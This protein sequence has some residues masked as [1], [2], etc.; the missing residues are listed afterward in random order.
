MIIQALYQRYQNQ[1]LDPD[2]GISPLYYS[3]SRISFELLIDRSGQLLDVVDIRDTNGRKLTAVRMIVPEQPARQSGV[4]PYFL[5]DKAEYLLAHYSISEQSKEAEKKRT[6]ARRKFAASKALH[7]QILAEARDDASQAVLNFFANWNVEEV[8]EHPALQRIMED[9][10]NG[11]DTNMVFRLQGQTDRVHEQE[12][13]KRV[14]TRYRQQ[15]QSSGQ[16]DYQCLVTGEQGVAI[17][18]TH[19]IKIKGVRDSQA[20]GAS[21][22][23]FNAPS[24]ES[25][26]KKQSYNAPVGETVAFGYATALN[27][28][29]ASQSN[30]II[31]FGGMTLVFWAEPSSQREA[32]EEFFLESFGS[33]KLEAAEMASLTE[34]IHDALNRVKQ[35]SDLTKEM[36]PESDKSFYILGLSPN[37]SRLAVRYFWQG[38]FGTLLRV[39][40]QHAADYELSGKDSGPEGTPRMYRILM[41]TMHVGNDGRKVGDGPPP[42]VEG[43]LFRAIL[44]GT[45]YPS[46]LYTTVVNRI[47]SDGMVNRLR[48]AMLKAHL[49]RYARIHDQTRYKEVLNVHVNKETTDPAYRLGRLFAV[50]ERAQQDAAGGPNRLNATIKDR[51]FSSASSTPAAVFPNLIRLASSHNS[52]SKYGGIRER[53]IG[54]ILSAL[55]PQAGFP[56]QLNIQEQGLF[57]LGYYQQ[58][59]SFFSKKAS[60]DVELETDESAQEQVVQ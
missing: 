36:L 51:F 4:K 59:E 43:D 58:R 9:L 49:L 60:A 41:E 45:A 2:S 48:A 53:E 10:D 6:D 33:E 16:S 8:R 3:V 5:S 27:Q 42:A 26:G 34:G 54:E 18:K 55:D 28:L 15:D 7:E 11:T 47:R 12:P 50:L 17:A 44:N 1:A 37:N 39:M 14:W 52:K 38:E 40:A 13:V 23:S 22:V 32:M 46:Y 19:D 25:Y 30:R 29:L 31:N 35:G 21:L 57:I 24:F 20:A 56:V